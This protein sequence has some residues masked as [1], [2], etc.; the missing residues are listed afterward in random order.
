MSVKQTVDRHQLKTLFRTSLRMDWRAMNNPMTGMRNR[1]SKI[2]GMVMMLGINLFASL[3]ISIAVFRI[4][5]PFSALVMSATAVMLLVSLQVLME[6]ANIIILAEDYE[7]IAPRPVNSK[8]FYTA[9]LLHFL[10]YVLIL[11]LPICILPSIL[12]AVKASR[13]I[14]VFYTFALYCSSSFL[15]A[16]TVMNIYT[17]I[18]T[19]IDRRRLERWLGYINMIFI[20]SLYLGLNTI[21]RLAREF[22]ADYNIDTIWWWKLIPTYWLGDWVKLL[23]GR[24]GITDSLLAVLGIVIMILLGRLA[25][26]YLSLRYAE[27][28]SRAVWSQRK[29]KAEKK[30]NPFMA[31][32]MK[33]AGPEEK[34]VMSLFRANF[35]NDA[36]F[37]LGIMAFIP[38]MIFYLIF[39]F[40]IRGTNVRDP[41]NPLPETQGVTNLLLGLVCVLIPYMILPSMHGSR[42]WKAAWIFF[43]APLDRLK[44]VLAMKRITLIIV[45]LPVVILQ[46]IIFSWLYHS[47]LHAFLHALFLGMLS[48]TGVT[49][50]FNFS[51]KLPFAAD[52]VNQNMTSSIF[53]YMIGAMVIFGSLLAVVGMVGYSGYIGWVIFFGSCLLFNWLLSLGQNRRIRKLFREWEFSA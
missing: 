43:A 14:Y 23:D 24:A 18:L 34:A 44:V 49:F 32:F 1:K 9:R 53:V 30:M 2:P 40:V 26:S 17:L 16:V 50:V 7:I 35:K 5:D 10:F 39:S 46:F 52:N 22:L 29:N 36:K 15:A 47:I 6:F 33:V 41:F 42:Y 37:R 8:T 11:T 12:L 27:S 21:P 25:V 3:F 31:L 38:L 51:V 19:R 13:F 28:L 48:L 45:V 20:L 4:A